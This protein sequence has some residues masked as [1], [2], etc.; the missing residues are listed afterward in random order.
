[1][2]PDVPLLLENVARSFRWADDAMD[3]GDFHAEITAATGCDLLLDVGNLYA[4]ALNAGRDPFELLA[5]HPLDRVA[6]LHVAGGLLEDGFYFDTHAHAVP[7]PVLDLVARALSLAGDVPVVLERDAAFP[8]FAELGGEIAR[9]GALARPTARA[10]SQTPARTGGPS[11][12]PSL[13]DARPDGVLRGAQGAIARLLTAPEVP[14]DRE[15]ARA[16]DILRRKRVDDALPLLPTLAAMGEPAFALAARCLEAAAR[17]VAM[18]AVADALRVARAAEDDP[19]LAGA[20]R[21]DAAL[22]RARFVV[23]GDGVRPRVAPFVE[24]VRGAAGGTRWVVKG[25]GKDATVRVIQG[26]AGT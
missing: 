2:L 14:V 22:L 20:A 16:R 15:M 21:G 12:V 6:M 11:A 19:A 26:R 1:M 8:A 3:E 4:N 23:E 18:V 5:R 13:E 17:P 9:L 25:P 7:G 10:G 24:R